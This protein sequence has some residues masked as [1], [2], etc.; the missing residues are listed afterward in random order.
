MFAYFTVTS[1]ALCAAYLLAAAIF[2]RDF[3]P[4]LN[5]AVVMC[6]ALTMAAYHFM[7]AKSGFEMD[8]ANAISNT[9]LHYISPSAAILDWLLFA[10][11]GGFKIYDPFLWTMIPTAYLAAVMIWG[12]Y[13]EWYP[14]IFLNVSEIGAR[15]AVICVGAITA[16]YVTGGYALCGIDKILRKNPSDACGATSP[17]R[18]G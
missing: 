12:D 9:L 8:G 5:G 4:R 10:K 17:S 2:G 1:N 13:V 3:L 11:K 15:T 6:V 7:L 18:G 16:A 14:Y